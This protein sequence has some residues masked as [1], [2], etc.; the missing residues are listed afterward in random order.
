MEKRHSGIYC[1]IV[2]RGGKSPKYYIGQSCVMKERWSQHIRQLRHGVA[3][4][5]ALQAAFNKYG[6]DAFSFTLLVTCTEDKLLLAKLEKFFFDEFSKIYG[7]DSMYNVNRESMTSAAGVKRSPQ[8][9]ENLRAAAKKRTMTEEHKEKLR[10]I[11]KLRIGSKLSPETI[12]K[13]TAAQKGV[14]RTEEWKAHMSKVMT[15][16]KHSDETKAKISAKKKAEGQKPSDEHM[17]KL[18]ELARG[19]KM[20]EH[21][22]EALKMSKLGKKKSPEDIARRT[23]TR[24]ANALLKNKAY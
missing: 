11:S 19:R 23:A 2:K 21:V 3:K 22:R 13:R 18:A 6:E 7:E 8:A 4:N 10:Q 20:P 9:L 14:K 17:E 12:A 16:K 1:I 24:R 15:G 5:P